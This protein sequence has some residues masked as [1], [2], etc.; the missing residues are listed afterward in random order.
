MSKSTATGVAPDGN[1]N[2]RMRSPRRNGRTEDITMG[3]L[4]P[5]S[6]QNTHFTNPSLERQNRRQARRAKR[7]AKDKMSDG[8]SSPEAKI[9]A[10]FFEQARF[11]NDDAASLTPTHHPERRSIHSQTESSISITPTIGTTIHWVGSYGYFIQDMRGPP[12]RTGRIQRPISVDRPVARV[13]SP[14]L[15]RLPRPEGP[16][17]EK[18]KME[19]SCVFLALCM[20][21]PPMLVIY[22]H[23]FL[24]GVMQKLS[25]GEILGFRKREKIIALVMGYTCIA[26]ICV[27]LMLLFI[28]LL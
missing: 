20:V 11:R 16:V 9:S 6:S 7:R 14:R 23:G 21:V 26:L 22:G 2:M 19:L 4:T 28:L 25:K 5:F 1:Q 12:T 3:V 17:I 27:G 8:E 15:H 10:E 13:E 24:D 18:R